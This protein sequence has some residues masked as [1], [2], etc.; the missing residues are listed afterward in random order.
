MTSVAAVADGEGDDGFGVGE[1]FLRV[2]AFAGV[3]GEPGH[4]TVMIGGEPLLEM[5]GVIGRRG[6]G[7]AAIVKAQPARARLQ[8]GFHGGGGWRKAR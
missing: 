1:N 3:A 6:G 2:G 5:S 4:F 7:D 8:G